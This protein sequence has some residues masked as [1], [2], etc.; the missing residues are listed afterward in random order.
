MCE[1]GSRIAD[2]ESGRVR[3][4]HA[5]TVN[6]EEA[7]KT[8]ED[9][10]MQLEKVKKTTTEDALQLDMVNPDSGVSYE[11]EDEGDASEQEASL[12][13][14]DDDDEDGRMSE[15]RERNDIGQVRGPSLP[16]PLVWRTSKMTEDR[17]RLSSRRDQSTKRS[18]L[19][20][21]RRMD[22]RRPPPLSKKSRYSSWARKIGKS[23]QVKK[24][25]TMDF[26]LF[27]H[28]NLHFCR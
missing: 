7:D 23:R 28:P 5:S 20:R 21:D 25:V 8:T 9:E 3:D 16:A 26:F 18:S 4:V 17:P 15:E 2:L 27:S 10:K 22:G 19:E 12:H 6:P 24:M 14:T 1:G 11:A 13:P